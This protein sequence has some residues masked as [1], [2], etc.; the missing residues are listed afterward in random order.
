VIRETGYPVPSDE[1]IQETL[2]LKRIM[3]SL[4]RS[5]EEKRQDTS[6]S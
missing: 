4:V 2:E 6:P 3:A 1:I 5:H